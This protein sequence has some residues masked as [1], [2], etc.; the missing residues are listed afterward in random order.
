L[1][2]SKARAAVISHNRSALANFCDPLSIEALTESSTTFSGADSNVQ[3]LALVLWKDVVV[4]IPFKLVREGKDRVRDELTLL[5]NTWPGWQR[6]EDYLNSIRRSIGRPVDLEAKTG[7]AGWKQQR[8]WWSKNG[9]YFRLKHLPA[10]LRAMVLKHAIGLRHYPVSPRSGAFHGSFWY[11]G[12]GSEERR[13]TSSGLAAI[14]IQRRLWWRNQTS[15]LF[16]RI[17]SSIMR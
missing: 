17:Q 5:C 15:M 10:E 3:K 16:S 12:I 13:T 2:F 9:K 6:F 14:L 8:I 7:E 1:I 4:R 11:Y